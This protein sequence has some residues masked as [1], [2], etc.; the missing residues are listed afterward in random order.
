ME[1]RNKYAMSQLI[2][3]VGKCELCG[4]KR[5]L[6]VHH[7][8][9]ITFGGEDV[10]EN[11][12]VVCC[13]CHAKLTP[14]NILTKMGFIERKKKNEY[15][16]LFAVELK[17]V[18]YAMLEDMADDRPSTSDL[19]D[20]FDVAVK[21]VLEDNVSNFGHKKGTKLITKKSIKSKEIIKERSKDFRGDLS[22]VEVMKLTGLA[23]G[24]YYK[25]KREM[26]AE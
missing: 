14:T 18:F 6:E 17:D 4:S 23:R 13:G 15:L 22:D 11:R 9:P 8:I 25:Y 20:T 12:I 1:K 24:T 7:I 10:D 3:E 19:C 21:C 5:G 2:K 16:N 26:K